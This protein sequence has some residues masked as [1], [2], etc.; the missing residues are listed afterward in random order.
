M[1]NKGELDGMQTTFF[2]NGKIWTKKTYKNGKRN[3]LW[4][5]YYKNGNLK[6]KCTFIEIPNYLLNIGRYEEFHENGQLSKLIHFD[7]NGKKNGTV[8]QYTK[9]GKI[10]SVTNYKNGIKNGEYISYHYDSD[11]ISNKGQYVDD[12]Q[13]GVFIYNN[14]KGE[15]IKKNYYVKGDF[16]VSAYFD[17]KKNETFISYLKDGKLIKEQTNE[18][19]NEIDLENINPHSNT[20]RAFRRGN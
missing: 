2:D 11:V 3:G 9:S 10:F 17:K 13:H 1:N 16:V 7:D 12:K 14:Q 8:N 20:Y 5:E 4:E 15:L 18:D 19:L 6:L